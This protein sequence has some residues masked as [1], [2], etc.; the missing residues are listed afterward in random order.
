MQQTNLI[1]DAIANTNYVR[2]DEEFNNLGNVT[3]SASALQG[4]LD[5]SPSRML[6]SYMTKPKQKVRK[7]K[8]I[9]RNDKCPCGSGKKYKHCCLSSGKYEE[10]E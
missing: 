3:T 9:G 2:T 1:M 6:N 10:Y 5:S 8:K 4:V 7:G